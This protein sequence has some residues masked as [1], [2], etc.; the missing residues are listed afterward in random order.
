MFKGP[1]APARF[2]QYAHLQDDHLDAE[3]DSRVQL[4]VRPHNARVRRATMKA[5]DFWTSLS[6]AEAERVRW[7]ATPVHYEEKPG[8]HEL[9]AIPNASPN[10]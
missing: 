6:R 9:I 5:Q 1:V 2:R 7:Q 3:P 4:T 10:W 8:S